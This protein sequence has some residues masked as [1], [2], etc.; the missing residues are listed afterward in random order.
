VGGRR[1]PKSAGS[2]HEDPIPE[3]GFAAIAQYGQGD[4]DEA[5][6]RF[7]WYDL[8]GEVGKPQGVGVTWSQILAEWELL[9]ADFHDIYGV[10]LEQVFRVRSYRWFIVRVRGLFISDS[11]LARHFA[12]PPEPAN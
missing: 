6:G 11:R 1:K 10:D 12:P 2:V 5:T 9:E 7:D 8:P 3:S 4:Y